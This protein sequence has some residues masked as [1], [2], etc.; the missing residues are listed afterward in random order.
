MLMHADIAMSQHEFMMHGRQKHCFA[1]ALLRSLFLSLSLS[2]T[3]THT[4]A[5]GRIVMSQH[6][7]MVQGRQEHHVRLFASP[8][9]SGGSGPHLIG[10]GRRVT[11]LEVI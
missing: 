11:T 8:L 1:A 7:F 4:Q 3:H 5:I 2:L 6:E 10:F 9:P